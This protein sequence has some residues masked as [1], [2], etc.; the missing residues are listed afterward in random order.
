MLPDP[1]R[2]ALRGWRR[3]CRRRRSGS[4]DCPGSA[5]TLCGSG[6][7]LCRGRKEAGGASEA[8]RLQSRDQA[9]SELLRDLGRARG[10]GCGASDERNI[11]WSRRRRAQPFRKGDP[12]FTRRHLLSSAVA[13]PAALPISLL[14]ID[15]SQAQVI[16][17]LKIFVPAA[18][19]GGWDQT[20]RTIEQ[21]L[22][23]TGAVKGVQIT[24]VGGAGGRGRAAAVPQPV[25][26]AGQ[27]PDGR[28]HG[29]GRRDHR[30]QEPGQARSGDADRA[31]H[32]RVPA[33]VVPGAVAVQ[34]PPRISPPR[35]RPIPPRFPSPAAR[36][37]APT[38]SCS[39]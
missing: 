16:D 19:G 32:R 11:V 31:A 39:A 37:A 33:L 12:M 22:R 15:R 13:V 4:R 21:V 8:I 29:D 17:L 35:S 36:P 14:S 30:Q 38:T 1:R 2:A 27:R 26:G 23:A 7:S 20:A 10:S 6:F 5:A 34:R 18:P 25:E 28:R 9:V 3:R 24:N